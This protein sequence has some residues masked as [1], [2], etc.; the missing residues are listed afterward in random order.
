ML[1][2]L[3]LNVTYEDSV[4]Q[5]LLLKRFHFNLTPPNLSQLSIQIL[6]VIDTSKKQK[7]ATIC[8]V[9]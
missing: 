3:C 4:P 7:N 9:T 5:C 6:I 2:T 1:P 8:R